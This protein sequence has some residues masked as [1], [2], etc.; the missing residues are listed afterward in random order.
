[1]QSSGDRL[2][3]SNSQTPQKSILQALVTEAVKTSIENNVTMATI[4]QEN[5]LFI[6]KVAQ[7]SECSVNH[8]QGLRNHAHALRALL[9][10]Q[11]AMKISSSEIE[12]EML[13]LNR[14]RSETAAK[15]NRIEQQASR[16]EAKLLNEIEQLKMLFGSLSAHVNVNSSKRKS[17]QPA[18]S[19]GEKHQKLDT[20]QNNEMTEY[21]Q[22]EAAPTH[23]VTHKSADNLI[24]ASKALHEHK[25]TTEHR[26]YKIDEDIS[27]MELYNLEKKKKKSS[28]K[29]T[30]EEDD[31]SPSSGIRFCQQ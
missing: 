30:V 31:T 4:T 17:T 20:C 23:D 26:G 19:E 8:S 15:L 13:S 22:Q 3:R 6:K 10:E 29:R 7:M 16:S 28:R 5:K 2:R 27:I 1:M 11:Y 25:C 21:I 9:S 18:N 12:E 24:V 14:H